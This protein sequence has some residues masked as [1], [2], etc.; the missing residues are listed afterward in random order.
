MLG[1]GRVCGGEIRVSGAFQ[2][3]GLCQLLLTS[4]GVLVECPRCG[5]GTAD[6]T[7]SAADDTCDLCPPRS[8]L[9]FVG[10][11]SISAVN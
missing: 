9:K 11:W 6:E 2:A 1:A 7:Y 8:A 4:E 3:A 10:K 5:N